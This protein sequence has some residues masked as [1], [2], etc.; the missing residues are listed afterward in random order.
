MNSA[1]NLI[2]SRLSFPADVTAEIVSLQNSVVAIGTEVSALQ[3]S[4]TI[5]RSGMSA[6]NNLA[7]HVRTLQVKLN[8]LVDKGTKTAVEPISG[9]ADREYVA[10]PERT[11]TVYESTPAPY[12]ARSEFQPETTS[13]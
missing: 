7:V 1:E 4:P 3:N 8:Q 13:L 2:N 5:S 9:V 12:P 10:E 11:G 6:V